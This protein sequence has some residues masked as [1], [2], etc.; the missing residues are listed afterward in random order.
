MDCCSRLHGVRQSTRGVHPTLLTLDGSMA[1][2]D[3]EASPVVDVTWA[4]RGRVASFVKSF[5]FLARR[6]NI[7]HREIVR[8]AADVQVAL[9]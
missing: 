7:V 6:N 4:S 2:V 1:A 5:L 8:S 9:L 3:G